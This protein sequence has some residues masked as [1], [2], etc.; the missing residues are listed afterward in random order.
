M[1]KRRWGYDAEGRGSERLA[2]GADR[3]TES[4]EEL[5]RCGERGK[6]RRRGEGG[7]G[8]GTA[9]WKGMG[10]VGKRT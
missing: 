10:G 9:R 3:R 6:L 5:G 4:I 7:G 1:D 2:V 8:R